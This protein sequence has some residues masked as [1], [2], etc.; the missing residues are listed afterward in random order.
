MRTL[1]ELDA[2]QPRPQGKATTAYASMLD[3]SMSPIDWSHTASQIHSWICG[4]NPWPTAS[5]T[6]GGRQLKILAARVVKPKQAGQQPGTVDSDLTVCCGEGTAL[7]VTEVQLAGK[8]RMSAVDFLRG[9]P[10]PEGAV[11]PC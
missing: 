10:V 8:K 11:L 7:Q 2:I 3:K 6:Y 5:T 9:H 4:L 1:A